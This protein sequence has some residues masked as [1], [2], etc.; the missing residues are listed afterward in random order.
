MTDGKLFGRWS[1]VFGFLLIGLTIAGCKLLSSDPEVGD[2]PVTTAATESVAPT[3]GG[4]S[5]IINIG[6]SLVIVFSDLPVTLPAFEE[7][8]NEQGVIT[9]IENKEFTAAG[10]TRGQLEK[11]IR[12]RYVPQYYVKMTVN[13]KPQERVFYVRGEVRQS[14]AQPYR[15]PMT[16]TKAIALAGDFT[17]FAQKKRVRLTRLNGKKETINCIKAQDDKSL[18]VPVFPG[19]SIF[20]PRRIF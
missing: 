8:V 3:N 10:K 1:A 5:E 9:L 4:S 14:G 18:D 13:I 2:I 6:D 11:E 19:D 12:E 7:R 15:G 17:D 16:I 20:V